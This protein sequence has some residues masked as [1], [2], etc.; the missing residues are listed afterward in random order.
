MPP[1]NTPLA[2]ETVARVRELSGRG[3]SLRRIAAELHI[4]ATSAK[5][6][7]D[8]GPAPPSRPKA[9]PRLPDPAPEAG[10]PDLPEPVTFGSS[11]VKF[12][13]PGKWLVMGDHHIPYHCP[14]SIRAAVEDG[15][16]FGATGVLLNGDVL[17]FYGLSRHYREPN[18]GRVKE[19]IEKG[20]EFLA[21]LRSQFPHADLTFKLGNHDERMRRFLAE[22]APELFD[23]DDLQL[24]RLLRCDDTGTEVVGDKRVIMLGKLAVLHGH[25]YRGGGGVQPSRWLYLRTGDSALTNHFH[26]V[27]HYTFRTVSDREVG[28]WSVGCLCSL[29]AEYMPL[30]QWGNGWGLVEVFAGG[31]YAVTNRQRLRCG[32]VV[33]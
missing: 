23:L 7:L 10:G 17:D 22:R 9:A 5:K 15:K 31:Q 30:N 12:D 33:G 21:W 2:P 8:R 6:Y 1:S 3:W 25:E 26:R 16:R 18:K 27:D 28:M 19:E 11:P 24:D 32:R 13:A 20:R 29:K 14:A 4:A